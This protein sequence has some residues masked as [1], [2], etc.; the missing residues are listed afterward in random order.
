MFCKS[1]GGLDIGD[2]VDDF[3][4]WLLFILLLEGKFLIFSDEM[5][6]WI[7][8]QKAFWQILE[9]NQKSFH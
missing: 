9:A 1:N 5:R 3:L 6:F 7:L 8:M 2:R 4:Q